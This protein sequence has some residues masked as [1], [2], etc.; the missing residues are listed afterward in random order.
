MLLVDT[1]ESNKLSLPY[2]CCRLLIRYVA[3]LNRA[4]NGPDLISHPD[5]AKA[6]W[7]IFKRLKGTV[8][9]QSV[10]EAKTTQEAELVERQIIKALSRIFLLD[11]DGT[12]PVFGPIEKMGHASNL[13]ERQ[14]TKRSLPAI[15]Q[16]AGFLRPCPILYFYLRSSILDII[17]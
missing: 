7:W 16:R 15:I 11:S 9:H 17:S 2:S 1:Q 13:C 14:V 12:R 8:I 3:R 4:T 6:R 5:C 10:P